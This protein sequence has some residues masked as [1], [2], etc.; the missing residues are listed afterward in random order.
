VR[1][2]SN[3]VL[4]GVDLSRCTTAPRDSDRIALLLCRPANDD[5]PA[6]RDRA[7]LPV[8]LGQHIFSPN[9]ARAVCGLGTTGIAQKAGGGR[10]HRNHDENSVRSS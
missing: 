9:E 6:R 1:V 4:R 10:R 3:E 7:E 2:T 8:D 5:H